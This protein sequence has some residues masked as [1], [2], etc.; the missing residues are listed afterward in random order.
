M[1]RDEHALKL[2]SVKV[3]L[4]LELELDGRH[5]AAGGQCA[6]SPAANV[7]DRA[8]SS[9]RSCNYA[10]R[11][12]ARAAPHA[13]MAPRPISLGFKNRGSLR[14]GLARTGEEG[15]RRRRKPGG[16]EHWVARNDPLRHVDQVRLVSVIRPS[17][18]ARRLGCLQLTRA[19]AAP[20]RGCVVCTPRDAS[21][22]QGKVRL[23]KWYSPYNSKEK[24]R[25]T[26]EVGRRDAHSHRATAVA[27]I[28]RAGR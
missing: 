17:H 25:T 4:R 20:T 21:S 2:D 13:T 9:G 23:T 26:R 7:R 18:P 10:R 24:T 1:H 27:C 3:L 6:S 11:N 19:R 15:R 28:M 5:C 16:R 14:G 22:R 12:A 8:R